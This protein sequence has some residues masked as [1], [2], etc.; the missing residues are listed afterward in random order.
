[1]TP[2]A[3]GDLFASRF[4]ITEV[5]PVWRAIDRETGAA[6]LVRPRASEVS[7]R[8]DVDAEACA[9]AL[10]AS[11][12]AHVRRVV[13][14]GEGVV[15]EDAPGPRYEGA[16]PIRDAA[17]CALQCCEVAAAIRAIGYERLTFNRLDLEAGTLDGRPSVRFTVPS[18]ARRGATPPRQGT[19]PARFLPLFPRRSEGWEE[20]C[21]AASACCVLFNLSPEAYVRAGPDEAER[22]DGAE[23]LRA[24]L[25]R[26][27]A[28]RDAAVDPVIERLSRYCFSL[29]DCREEA[30]DPRLT[31]TVAAVAKLLADVIGT[32]DARA[33]AEAVERA[34]RGRLTYDWDAIATDGEAQLSRAAPQRKL[35]I[36]LPLAEAHHQRASALWARGDLDGALT[37]VNRALALDRALPYL[38]TRSVVLADL[39]RVGEAR[40]AIDAAFEAIDAL[41]LRDQAIRERGY[42]PLERVPTYVPDD[43]ERARAFA[44]RGAIALREKRP[45]EALSDL[46]EAVRRAPSNARYRW[47]LA[48]CLARLERRDEAITHARSSLALDPTEARRARYERLFGAPF[49]A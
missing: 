6:V 26:R 20:A 35:Y 17:E 4:E 44:A 12:V 37:A 14:V 39:N 38:V 11:P 43:A 31:F 10:A 24:R 27:R 7:W 21:V 41:T 32:P 3:V 13:F 36:A 47:S 42:A 40:Y 33:R 45:R 49:V 46:E 22:A 25:A 34:Q 18:L 29:D 8:H 15:F 1:M 28:S 23:G 9:R 19:A 16:M 5:G 30:I 48:S 2:L